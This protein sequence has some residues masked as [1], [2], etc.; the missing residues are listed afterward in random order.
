MDSYST[1]VLL[2]AALI[3]LSALLLLRR[4]NEKHQEELIAREADKEIFKQIELIRVQNP[5]EQDLQAYAL[6]ESERQKIWKSLSTKT[7]ITPRKIYQFSFDLIREIAATYNPDSENPEF[8]ASV[9]DLLE[10][11]YRIIERVRGYLEEFPLNTIKNLNIQDILRYRGYYDRLSEL[12]LVK[13]AK[14]HKYL[15]TIG[16]YAWMGYNVINPWYWGRKVVFT[17]GKEGTFRYLLTAIITI[18]GEEAILVY[19][20]RNIKAKAVAVEKNIAFEM[21]NMAVIDGVV[22]QEEYEVI[23]NFILYNPRLD[24]QMKV[25]L[26]RALLRKRPVKSAISPDTY[27]DKEKK[28]LLAEVERVAKA[29]KLGI[30][31][32]REALRSL[33][34]SLALTSEY[35]T[36]LELAPQ[37]EVHSWDLM[38]QNRQREAAILRLMVQAGTVEGPVPESLREYI[39]QRA[40]SYPL[41]F[42]EE[43]QEGI[44]RE[45][46]VP[47]SQDTL[48][49]LI[50]TKSDK[51]RAL[52]EVLDALL[53]YLPFT[54]K[55]EEFYTLIVSALDMKKAG[56]TILTK[57]L[58]QLL[59]SGKLIEKPPAELTKY[60]S[61]LLTQDEQI[62]ALQSTATKYKFLT[63]D[64]TPK[65][66]ETELWI[67]VTT[68][69]VLV[70]AAMKI[71]GTI[72]QHHVEFQDDLTVRVEAGKLSDTYILQG[73]PGEIRLENVL[74]RSSNLK[75]AL[76]QY[77]GE[78]RQK[79]ERRRR[80]D[81]EDE[82]PGKQAVSRSSKQ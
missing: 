55:K 63:R 57:R 46:T 81:S 56:D 54:R 26:L 38:Q 17:A 27:D 77:L 44:L 34:E 68:G 15:Y 60:L 9:S 37:A 14:K 53:W 75:N 5:T 29:D 67:C 4:R 45:E 49:N 12:E 42:R 6:I 33:E 32:K 73:K 16:K 76:Q 74:F 19:S 50:P 47:T 18:V 7:S 58:E 52:S 11:N 1:A 21:I 41:P 69:R 36:Q 70:L 66:K 2:F 8:Q 24:D 72:Y 3:L 51:E 31:K 79:L 30:L 13:L 64:E 20:K 82:E 25:T 23:L 59:P 35:R 28:R 71:N 78:S 61:R 39:I 65:Q 62:R 40:T 22:S 10:L 48:T 80:E 43:E